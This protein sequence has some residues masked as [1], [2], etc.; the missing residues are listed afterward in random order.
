MR[1][2]LSTCTATYTARDSSEGNRN[3]LSQNA[4]P[5]SDLGDCASSERQVFLPLRLLQFLAPS[6]AN[7]LVITELLTHFL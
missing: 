4:S 1:E 3:Q 7:E 2:H 6:K 5:N